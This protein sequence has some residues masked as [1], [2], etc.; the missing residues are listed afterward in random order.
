MFA[1]ENTMSFHR[2]TDYINLTS[3][4]YNLKNEAPNLLKEL[5]NFIDEKVMD[6]L[7]QKG[8][9]HTN[10]TKWLLAGGG[11]MLL[12]ATVYLWYI[13]YNY[14]RDHAAEQK[15]FQDLVH[16]LYRQIEERC[17]SL[18]L[19]LS[20]NCFT[21]KNVPP[22]DHT[23]PAYLP[24]CNDYTAEMEG[25]QWRGIATPNGPG[26]S[27]ISD[28]L[29]G[30]I[31][32]LVPSDP[33][34]RDLVGNY[35]SACDNIDTNPGTLAP[36]GYGLMSFLGSVAAF[37]GSGAQSKKITAIRNQI[38]NQSFAD[39]NFSTANPVHQQILQDLQK[40]RITVKQMLENI[41]DRSAK[42]TNNR[43]TLHNQTVAIPGREVT[44]CVAPQK[45]S[46]VPA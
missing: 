17:T 35:T 8:N 32:K 13:G 44:V 12:G 10:T 41:R 23:P 15:P 38:L 42:L 22:M 29:F 24:H 19:Y 16:E 40:D 14:M 45:P 4:R 21:V 6:A 11:V 34:L 36:M 30:E 39:L 28:Y 25:C 37:C 43:S 20:E 26:R 31:K 1:K 18:Y 3:P 9:N 2:S 33:V 5:N 27:P 7:K 46:F